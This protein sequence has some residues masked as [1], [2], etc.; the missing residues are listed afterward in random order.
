MW[1]EIAFLICRLFWIFQCLV[2]TG[3]TIVWKYQGQSCNAF[4]IFKGAFLWYAG[5]YIMYPNIR[6]TL[7]RALNYA[8]ESVFNTVRNIKLWQNYN[9]HNSIAFLSF[10]GDNCIRRFRCPQT[11]HLNGPP[12][13]THT[14]TLTGNPPHACA[15]ASTWPE[16]RDD[17][18]THGGVCWMDAITIPPRHVYRQH[19][20]SKRWCKHLDSDTQSCNQLSMKR[21]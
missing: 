16:V 4:L 3:C 8:L 17:S 18:V 12:P 15:L 6:N 2:W 14:Y 7:F 9:T 19:G 5:K 10:L 20:T 11:S 21:V 1:I 13:C